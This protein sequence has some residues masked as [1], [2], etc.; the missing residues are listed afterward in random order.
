M[1]RIKRTKVDNRLERQI[2]TGMVVST[3][4]LRSVS[5]IY[6]P[7][8]I[9]IPFVRTI[10]DWCLKHHE[11]YKVAPGPHIRDLF[12]HESR[13]PE[14]D[15]DEAELIGDFLEEISNEHERADKFN[16]E[17]ILDQ[18]VQRFKKQKLT[19]LADEIRGAASSG[20][21]ADAEAFLAGYKQVSRYE[22][23]GVNP[24]TNQDVIRHAFESENQP[25]FSLP[26]ALGRA[27]GPVCRED[28]IGIMGPEKRGKT[29]WLMFYGIMAAKARCNVAFFQVGDMSEA[30]FTRRGHVYLAQ[31]SFKEKYCGPILVPILDCYHNQWDSCEDENRA[32]DFGIIEDEKKG[33]LA[34]FEDAEQDGYKP[35]TYCVK[36]YPLRFR[37][38]HWY[39]KREAVEPLTWREAIRNGKQFEK[40]IKGRNF[41]LSTHSNTS[42]NIKGI[43][44][45]LS[46]W[47]YF[48]GF[49]PDVVII[50]Y[51][52]I[53]AP[54]DTRKEHRHQQNDS[55]KAMRALSQDLKCAVIT[56]TQADADS[57]DKKSLK[58]TN[59]SED[60]RKYAHVT[61]FH[62]LNQTPEEKRR[63]VMRYSQMLA[64]EDDFDIL[65]QVK[66][67]Q[68]LQIGRPYLESYL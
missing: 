56:A 40:R 51:A 1:K 17:Y 43:R 28:F 9:E 7:G 30:Q 59:F 41:K 67:L 68:C 63:G 16:V 8:L 66:V 15:S 14:M 22:T 46:G 42:I 53:L 25:L 38:A 36:R 20:E 2:A 23:S 31:R 65:R 45:I 37:G 50:D 58:L 34:K 35:C 54:E 3:D 21:L 4:F 48:E 13:K 18:T 10:A 57:Y 33:T 29:W 32:C 44:A 5:A 55:W 6:E 64:R 60:K 26:G 12:D 62:G 47:E 61:A 19:I 52:D 49:V 39:T 27:L 11:T 24:F